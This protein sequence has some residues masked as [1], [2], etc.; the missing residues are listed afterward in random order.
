MMNILFYLQNW[1]LFMCIPC[2]FV[3]IFCWILNAEEST[4]TI[5]RCCLNIVTFIKINKC[6]RNGGIV[7][8]TKIFTF[9]RDKNKYNVWIK[10]FCFGIYSWKTKLT[11]KFWWCIIIYNIMTFMLRQEIKECSWELSML[12]IFWSK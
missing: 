9:N 10:V 7:F 8:C 3:D 4:T 5:N 6:W 1:E 2:N 12:S 11:E